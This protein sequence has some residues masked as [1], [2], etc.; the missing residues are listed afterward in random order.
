MTL[1]GDHIRALI[2]EVADELGATDGDVHTIIVVAAHFSPGGTCATPL[3]T[4]T[5]S[6]TSTP[7]FAS[8][9]RCSPRHDEHLD[10]SIVEELGRGGYDISPS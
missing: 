4:S 8:Q 1:D 3:K 2:S 9:S 7:N 6:A 5:P 10:N